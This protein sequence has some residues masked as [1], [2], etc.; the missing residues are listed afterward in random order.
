MSATSP[1]RLSKFVRRHE[2]FIGIDSDGCAFDTMEIKHKE[3]FIPN[4]IKHFGLQP[5]AKYAREAAEFVNLYS[6]WRGINRFP[7]LERTLDLLAERDEV[8]AR[9]FLVPQLPALRAWV[10]AEPQP[11]NPTLEAALRA[12]G[13]AA[14][15]DLTRVLRW[16]RAV[17]AAIADLVQG[18]P[19]FPRVR[20]CLEKAAGRADVI[21]VSATPGEALQREWREHDLA[22]YVSL[23]AGQELG[24]K[25]D[26]LRL[27]AGGKYPPGHVL[28]VGDAPGDL[29][30]ARANGALFFPINP[31]DE[32]E[33]WARLHGEGL[34]R[35]FR[36]A[37]GGT[38]EAEHIADFE[39]RLPESPPWKKPTL[40]RG[41]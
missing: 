12:S 6:K 19:P 34:D 2:F 18:V 7:A 4:T 11:S 32:T 3:C 26:H 28:M 22:G 33:S 9:R 39:A 8:R 15:E 1:A 23:I 35:F 36:G 17:N 14:A 40:A 16:S 21:V 25:A 27:T 20:E 13:G 24:T 30:A 31:G 10:A 29:A 41:S 37:Y 5:V 38:Y